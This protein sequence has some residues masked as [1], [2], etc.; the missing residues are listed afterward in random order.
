MVMLFIIFFHTP[1]KSLYSNVSVWNFRIYILLKWVTL[2]NFCVCLWC[3]NTESSLLIKPTNFASG[4]K[5]SGITILEQ[6]LWNVSLKTS[7]WYLNSYVQYSYTVYG[8]NEYLFFYTQ[9]ILKCHKHVTSL[10]NDCW[11]AKINS[12]FSVIKWWCQVFYPLHFDC[13]HLLYKSHL[14]AAFF[15]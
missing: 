15:C 2:I 12:V 11:R 8:Y 10:P 9:I 7:G 1:P 13:V 3:T 6:R 4:W 14:S 5:V